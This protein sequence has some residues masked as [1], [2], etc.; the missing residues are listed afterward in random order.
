MVLIMQ[1]QLAVME[2]MEE[3]EITQVK[4]PL[5]EEVLRVLTEKVEVQEINTF[6][7]E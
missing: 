1:K 3:G 6:F 4:M 7:I 5:V 2:V